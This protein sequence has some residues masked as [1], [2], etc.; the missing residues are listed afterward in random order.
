MQMVT[1]FDTGSIVFCTGIIG[2]IECTAAN[3]LLLY[4]Q[5][6]WS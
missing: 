6:K 2:N 3:G 1:G 4:K 5:R